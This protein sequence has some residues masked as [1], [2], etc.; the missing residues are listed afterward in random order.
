ME[1]ET[2]LNIVI[3]NRVFSMVKGKPL[4]ERFSPILSYF[5]IKLLFLSKSIHCVPNIF[6]IT[7]EIKK[8]LQ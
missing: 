7:S 3:V 8:I 4:E 2:S 1:L 6:M 5:I